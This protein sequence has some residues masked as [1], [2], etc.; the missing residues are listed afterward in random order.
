MK[1]DDYLWNR[2]GVP[3]PE[4]ERLE[5]LLGVLR[6]RPAPLAVPEAFPSRKAR[7]AVAWRGPAV[8]LALAATVVFLVGISWPPADANRT[9]WTVERIAGSPRL[10]G[11]IVDV[12]SRFGTDQWVETGPGSTARVG[13]NEVGFV[14]IGPRS[15]VRLVRSRAGEHRLALERGVLHAHIWASPGQFYVETPSAT[16]VDLGCAY[17]LDVGSDGETRLSVTLGWVGLEMAGRESFVPAGATCTA[18]PGRPPGIPRFDDAPAGLVE[19]LAALE[20][21]GKAR[22]DVLAAALSAAR[23]RDAV[24]IWHLLTRVDR[25]SAGSVCDR[26]A[27]LAPPPPGVDR[28]QILSGDRAALDAW[29]NGLGLGDAT[30][31][32]RFRAT[33]R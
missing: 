26:L 1:G 13:A 5:R 18:R 30:W 19:A 24:T 23:P 7:P 4:V 6:H 16:A 14:D 17:T 29:W 28:E 25:A 12:A 32:R 8:W 9:R 33:A 21:G 10:G 3:D 22:P 15:R 31:Y 11:A 27:A 20:A 2:S